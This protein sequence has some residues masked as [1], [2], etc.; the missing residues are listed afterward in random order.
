[1]KKMMLMIG[2][3]AGIAVVASAD[4]ITNISDRAVY[5]T[6]NLNLTVQANLSVAATPLRVGSYTSG[7]QYRSGAVLF[8]DLGGILAS[9]ESFGNVGLT[10]D[11]S[12][13]TGTMT[14][15]MGTYI[16]GLHAA[17]DYD[18]YAKSVIAPYN[19]KNAGSAAGQTL[20]N[21][22]VLNGMGAGGGTVV[23]SGTALTDWLSANYT[24]GGNQILSII[25]A[26]GSGVNG[27]NYATISEVVGSTTLSYTVIPE[28]AT[29]G[30]IC[31]SGIGMLFVRRL[32][33]M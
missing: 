33:A 9:G 7:L 32:L 19:L 17:A 1:M 24:V 28:P 4:L 29:L 26:E 22:D 18:A 14:N 2:L 31:A 13:I 11:V 12:S 15:P 16:G 27:N 30:I 8:F 23:S 3:I 5:G 10:F 20:I 6:A 21:S 25:I